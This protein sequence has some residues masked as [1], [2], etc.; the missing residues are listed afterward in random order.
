MENEVDR[1]G[2]NFV[3]ITDAAIQRPFLKPTRLRDLRYHSRPRINARG[4]EIPPNGFGDVFVEIGRTVFVDLDRLDA[5]IEENR[6]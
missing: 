3:T 4:E 2:P 5:K 1:R 6:G